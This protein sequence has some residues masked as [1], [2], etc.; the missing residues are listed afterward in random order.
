MSFGKRLQTLRK[1]KG[2]SQEELAAQLN[3]SRQA[4]SKWETDE[5]APDID[6]IVLLSRI[7][8]V[9]TDSLLCDTGESTTTEKDAFDPFESKRSRVN[10]NFIIK[11]IKK[12]GYVAG[13]IISVYGAL[14]L[15]LMRFAHYMFNNML[16]PK[17]FDINFSSLPVTFKAPLYLTDILSILAILIIIGG[18]VLAVYLK[19]KGNKDRDK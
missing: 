18:I 15:L 16:F 12:K 19:K 10:L 7:F 11:L 1:K 5:S 4:I 9:S 2:L 13:I 3:I 14:A 8:E 6:K 17:G